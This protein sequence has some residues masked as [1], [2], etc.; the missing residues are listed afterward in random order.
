MR[1]QQ[2]SRGRSR[3]E[4]GNRERQQPG[5]AKRGLRRE[6]GVGTASP[7]LCGSPGLSIRLGLKSRIWVWRILRLIMVLEP[8]RIQAYAGRSWNQ[9][10]RTSSYRDSSILKYLEN[11]MQSHPRL[12][13]KTAPL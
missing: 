8:W 5:R 12:V 3:R 4:R 2:E 11:S 1:S 9:P 6:G 13:S 7:G 10:P